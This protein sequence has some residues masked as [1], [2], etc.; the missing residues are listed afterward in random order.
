ME[1][2]AMQPAEQLHFGLFVGAVVLVYFLA[3]GV[4]VRLLL[5]RLGRATLAMGRWAVWTRRVILGLALIGTLCIAYGFFI[6]PSWPEIVRVHVASAKLV[7]G[8]RPIRIVQL[9]DIHS[10]AKPRLEERLPALIA[11]EQP[12]LIVFTGDAVNSPEGLPVFRRLITRLAQLAPAFAV[13][14]N[15]DVWYWS[16]FDLFGGT[17]AHELKGGSRRDSRCRDAGL[18]RGRAGRFRSMDRAG[19]GRDPF[20]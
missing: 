13:Q 14:G 8:A 16:G 17:S 7:P 11:R 6:E 3:A 1:V 2:F 4:L 19:A 10:D 5:R 20:E 12:D 9:S 18:G 15:W